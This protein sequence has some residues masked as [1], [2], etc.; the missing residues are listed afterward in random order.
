L[1][2]AADE[3]G[4][5]ALRNNWGCP[6]RPMPAEATTTGARSVA[7]DGASGCD[8]TLS[9]VK[10]FDMS[11]VSV[12]SSGNS[13]RASPQN[14]KPRTS[15]TLSSTRIFTIIAPDSLYR[16]SARW[17][18]PRPGIFCRS[19]A[20]RG[21]FCAATTSRCR[22]GIGKSGFCPGGNRRSKTSSSIPVSP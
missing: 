22:Y 10:L 13:S 6:G 9:R 8:A 11:S 16:I 12:S 2:G 18:S 4:R 14:K 17:H 5:S 15:R 1:T 3:R 7:T 21:G 20:I 19:L